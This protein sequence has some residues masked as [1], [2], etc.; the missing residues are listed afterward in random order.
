MPAT[1]K[2]QQMAAGAALANQAWR[3]DEIIA[4]GR[5]GADVR[6]HERAAA[7]SD[8]QLKDLAQTK[9]R[10]LP[11]RKSSANP[12]TRSRSATIRQPAR[13]DR[14]GAA[15]PFGNGSSNTKSAP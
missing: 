9:R 4:G 8:Q 14:N 2:K 3:E 1:S 15:S 7:V 6:I 12:P 11:T 13:Q 10:S 5:V